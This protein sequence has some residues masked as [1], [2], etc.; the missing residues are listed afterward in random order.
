M[1]AKYDPDSIQFHRKTR[2]STRVRVPDSKTGETKPRA[3][4]SQEEIA[5]AVGVSVKTYERWESGERN[6][7]KPKVL[8][9]VF[10]CDVLD[11]L[12]PESKQGYK[13][14]LVRY[15]QALLDGKPLD[16]A[17]LSSQVLN[18]ERFFTTGK[19]GDDE[20]TDEEVEHSNET[21]RELAEM[22]RG[23]S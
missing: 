2:P 17:R 12:T 23:R 22:M 19:F 16:V 20:L 9:E 11:L 3:W 4:S 14:L 21:E 7:S 6:C 13:W 5:D 8:A 10:G 15:K 1:Y 18:W